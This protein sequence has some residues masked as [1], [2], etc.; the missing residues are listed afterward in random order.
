MSDTSQRLLWR[1]PGATDTDWRDLAACAQ[2]DPELFFP[3]GTSGPARH[4]VDDAK[5]ICH[6]CPVRVNCL[7]W[8]LERGE[9]AG[10]WGG[11]TEDER[12]VLRLAR[13]PR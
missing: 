11:T 9:D 10:V 8:A 4:Q 12:R 2:A 7:R 13:L 3:I 5:K 1:Q 6:G